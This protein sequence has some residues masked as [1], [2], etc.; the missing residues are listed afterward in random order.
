M[1]LWAQGITLY[2]GVAESALGIVIFWKGC[3]VLGKLASQ[4]RN[5]EMPAVLL[6]PRDMGCVY[7][8]ESERLEKVEGPLKLL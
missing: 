2:S 1:S 4:K 5:F 8:L 7:C 3:S 6:W